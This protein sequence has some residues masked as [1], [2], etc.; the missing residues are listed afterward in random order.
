MIEEI[1]AHLDALAKPRGAMGRLEALAVELALTQ[2]RI[3]ARTS[4]RQAV[5]FAGDHGC[6]GRGCRRGRPR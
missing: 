6:V 4:P 1:R 3:D 2:G 5:L